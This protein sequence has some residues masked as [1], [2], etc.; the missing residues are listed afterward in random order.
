MISCDGLSFDPI[1]LT[2]AAPV[3]MAL[4]SIYSMNGFDVL[5]WA[6]LVR[7]AVRILS[8]GSRRLWLPFGALA[9]VG[10]EN[11]IDVAL[12]GGGRGARRFDVFRDRWIWLGG[13]CAAALFAPHLVW[14]I[15]HDWPT[16]EFVANAQRQKITVLGPIGFVAKQFAM[17]GPVGFAFALTGAGWLL[18]GRSA[19]AQYS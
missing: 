11:K 16:R 7:I 3:Y 10:L 9:G 4:F 19:L 5:I 15:V 14:Q 6:G 8:G 12:L 2:A 18:A 1:S 17:A 13:A